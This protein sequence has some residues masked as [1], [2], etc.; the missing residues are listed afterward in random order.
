MS[1][2]LYLNL[3]FALDFFLNTLSK[4]LPG[5]L[6]MDLFLDLYLDLYLE[7]EILASVL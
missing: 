4:F 2:E 6:L 7:M 3:A 1:Q 5:G